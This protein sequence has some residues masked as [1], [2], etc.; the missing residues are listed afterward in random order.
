MRFVAPQQRLLHGPS[1]KGLLV[2]DG[3]YYF[4]LIS[5]CRQFSWTTRF[6]RAHIGRLTTAQPDDDDATAP[7]DFQSLARYRTYR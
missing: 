6:T 4:H 7:A 1:A 3:V 2:D 5:K